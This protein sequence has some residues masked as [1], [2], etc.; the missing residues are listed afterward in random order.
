MLILNAIIESSSVILS[1]SVVGSFGKLETCK[2]VGQEEAHELESV[3]IGSEYVLMIE[4]IGSE[5]EKK[6]LK[7]NNLGIFN[8]ANKS[9]ISLFHFFFKFNIIKM[10]CIN[11]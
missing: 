9:C 4:E 7:I 8:S 1:S 2:S 5:E 10:R 6:S 3:L 11:H